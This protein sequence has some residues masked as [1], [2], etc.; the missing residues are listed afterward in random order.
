MP[1]GIRVISVPSVSF[2]LEIKLGFG[3]D[4]ILNNNFVIS[5]IPLIVLRTDLP[6]PFS[7]GFGIVSDSATVSAGP[8]PVFS[9]LL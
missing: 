6:W 7:A 3:H 1:K 2:S 4:L 8:F 5:E 9:D